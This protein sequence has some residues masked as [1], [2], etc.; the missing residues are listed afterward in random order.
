MFAQE[1][2]VLGLPAEQLVPLL[3]HRLAAHCNK[4]NTNLK[5]VSQPVKGRSWPK[6]HPLPQSAIEITPVPQ[7]LQRPLASSTSKHPK[8]Q[9]DTCCQCFCWSRL[10]KDL[11]VDSVVIYKRRVLQ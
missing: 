6:G 7:L 8:S 3:Q 2:L 1:L 11:S 5:L 10:I 9:C 4:R